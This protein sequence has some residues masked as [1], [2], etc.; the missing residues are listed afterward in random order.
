MHDTQER[1]G[2]KNMFYSTIKTI[3]DI[4]NTENHEKKKKKIKKI[5]D[6]VKNLLT[7]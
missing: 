2:V 7:I 6:L 4:S 5:K 1:L 3:K